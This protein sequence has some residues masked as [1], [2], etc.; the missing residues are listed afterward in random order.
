MNQQEIKTALDICIAQ[1]KKCI[2]EFTNTF[3][4]ASSENLMYG[5][6]DNIEWNWTNGFW[7][8][9]VWIAYEMSKDPQLKEAALVHIDHFYERIEKQL[10]VDFHDMGFLYSLSCVAAYKLIGDEKAKKAAVMAADKLISRYQPIGEFI[11]AWGDMGAADNYRLIIDCLL[12]LPLLHWASEVTGEVKYQEV[13]EKH[14]HTTMKCIFREDYSAYHTYFF[15]METGEPVKGVSHQGYSNE[16]TWARGQAWGIYG[17]ALA[18]RYTG[19][20]EYIEIFKKV[21]EYFWKH[22]PADMVPYWDF[23]FS[24][25]SGEPKDCSAASIAVCGM[26][27]MAKHMS[28]EDADKHISMAE[29]ILKSLYDNYAVKDFNESKGMLKHGTYSKSSP[30][31]TCDNEGVDE[32]NLWGD[33]FYM[34]ALIRLSKDWEPYW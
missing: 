4:T 12:N 11:Q 15:D 21:T 22:L 10:C 13:A 2:P 19:R 3:P 17:C 28:E 8:G 6:N 5:P 27:E 26:L 32:C 30:Y 29:R 9:E 20:E 34:E 25:D 33:Y 24:D 7:T 31:N 1:V 14:I 16:S 23:E 18:Y